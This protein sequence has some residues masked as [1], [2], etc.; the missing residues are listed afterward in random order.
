MLKRS[1]R[2]WQGGQLRADL[3]ERVPL[4]LIGFRLECIAG[5]AGKRFLFWFLVLDAISS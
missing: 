1:S 3:R 2:G 5:I 4:S